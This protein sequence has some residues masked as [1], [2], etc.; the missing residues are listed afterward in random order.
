MFKLVLDKDIEGV[1]IGHPCGFNFAFNNIKV[2]DDAGIYVNF[3]LNPFFLRRH[4]DGAGA[5]DASDWNPPNFGA[6]TI[7]PECY[8]TINEYNALNFQFRVIVQI[9]SAKVEL[10]W[11]GTYKDFETPTIVPYCTINDYENDVSLFIEKY[12]TTGGRPVTAHVQV[13]FNYGNLIEDPYKFVQDASLMG[14]YVSI[15]N[16]IT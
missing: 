15:S 2:R 12:G 1:T 5:V 3:S 13:Y 6:K 8:L 11:I 4:P 7:A 9:E 10:P 14:K 16:V